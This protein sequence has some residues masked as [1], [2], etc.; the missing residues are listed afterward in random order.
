MILLTGVEHFLS[1]TER[2]VREMLKKQGC[3]I[4]TTLLLNSISLYSIEKVY[5]LAD[6]APN[7]DQAM[8][9]TGLKNQQ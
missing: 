5:E 3:V 7:V 2:D 4:N 1:R 9:C 8:Y 6:C